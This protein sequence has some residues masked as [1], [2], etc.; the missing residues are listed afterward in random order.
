MLADQIERSRAIVAVLSESFGDDGAANAD[1]D[2]QNGEQDQRRSN[3]M[4]G[5]TE[6]TL[7]HPSAWKHLPTP[8]LM[9]SKV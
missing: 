7:H 1:E 6:H 5:I 9:S 3:Q 4:S 2:G 8:A